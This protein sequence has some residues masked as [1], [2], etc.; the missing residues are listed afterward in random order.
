MEALCGG[1]RYSMRLSA[2]SV[3]R[4]LAPS[5]Q[6]WRLPSSAEPVYGIDPPLTP[7]DFARSFAS[8]ALFVLPAR[9]RL[10]TPSAFVEAK[11]IRCHLLIFVW[12]LH[13]ISSLGKPHLAETG[14]SCRR[15]PN[16]A[17]GTTP[18]SREWAPT[19]AGQWRTNRMKFSLASSCFRPGTIE[20]M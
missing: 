6:N 19:M 9:W 4:D 3:A 13:H 17:S 7:D 11:E 12:F 18:P 16:A 1:S 10:Q 5:H 8:Y 15:R 2:S 20:A 14:S